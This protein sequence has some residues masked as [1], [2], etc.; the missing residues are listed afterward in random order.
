[1]ETETV[2][3]VTPADGASGAN[4][5]TNVTV[6]FNEAMDEA[7]I[8]GSTFELR[9]AGSNLVAATVTYS[10]ST[11]TVTLQPSSVLAYNSSYTAT[12]RGTSTGVSRSSSSEI[13]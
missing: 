13:F 5:N 9:D 10:A 3:A 11:L 7:T 12:V 8:T 1:M 4:V 2:T 6:T